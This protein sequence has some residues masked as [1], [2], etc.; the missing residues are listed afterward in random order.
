MKKVF[1]IIFVLFA[2]SLIIQYV[3]NFI[4]NDHVV[5]YSILSNNKSYMV[6]E[7][8]RY[9]NEENFYDFTVTDSE[10]LF[11]TFSF[12]EDFNKQEEVIKD[13]EFFTKS[14]LL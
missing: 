13:I 11:Y 1:P 7:T 5:E 12:N 8:F 4:I 2:L 9:E 14:S 6:K 10:D 3:V